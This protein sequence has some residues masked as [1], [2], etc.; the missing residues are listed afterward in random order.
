MSPSE[1]GFTRAMRSA[2]SDKAVANG[3]WQRQRL[4]THSDRRPKF[5]TE[6][7]RVLDSTETCATKSSLGLSEVGSCDGGSLDEAHLIQAAVHQPKK[8][9]ILVRTI[10]RKEEFDQILGEAAAKIGPQWFR[11][12]VLGGGAVYRERVYCYELYHQIRCLWPQG[13]EGF[14]SGGVDKSGHPRFGDLAPKPDLL[15]HVPGDSRNFVVVEVKS[16]RGATAGPIKDD[17]E[18]LVQ[19]TQGIESVYD[20]AIYLIFG[21]QAKRAADRV[22]QHLQE[23]GQRAGKIEVWNHSCAYEAAVR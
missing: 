18:K 2:W 4:K 10:V 14:L 20:R 19:F 15:V 6:N 22:L 5:G 11:L 3:G 13:S 23:H 12:P 16:C 21:E 8:R 1:P 17:V 7:N 9:N